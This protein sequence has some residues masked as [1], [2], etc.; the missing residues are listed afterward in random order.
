MS[1]SSYYLEVAGEYDTMYYVGNVSQYTGDDSDTVG[2][3]I[4]RNNDGDVAD[5]VDDEIYNAVYIYDGD[6]GEIS[7]AHIINGNLN[8]DPTIGSDDNAVG[9]FGTMQR[10]K[11]D[12]YMA[13]SIKGTQVTMGPALVR[14]IPSLGDSDEAITFF[15]DARMAITGLQFND[16]L[17]SITQGTLYIKKGAAIE[18][19]V[20]LVGVGTQRANIGQL[21]QRESDVFDGYNIRTDGAV[22]GSAIS[23]GSRKLRISIVS[24]DQAVTFQDDSRDVFGYAKVQVDDREFMD[25]CATKD[26]SNRVSGKGRIVFL[27][28]KMTLSQDQALVFPGLIYRANFSSG[29]T[30]NLRATDSV[31]RD[32]GVPFKFTDNQVSQFLRDDQNEIWG[33]VL[34]AGQTRAPALAVVDEKSAQKN[35]TLVLLGGP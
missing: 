5:V 32:S 7:L 28:D 12:N 11:G 6:N 16:A 33:Y 21:I 20:D 10:L 8:P 35:M 14:S 31:K 23:D 2:I 1:N 13:T 24:V 30:I 9:I 22:N 3:K 18:S 4:D 27:S 17:T 19:T 34:G 15:G 25:G 29:K 26:C